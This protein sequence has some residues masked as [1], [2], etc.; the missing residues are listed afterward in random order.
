[1]SI[2]DTVEVRQVAKLGLS[3]VLTVIYVVK[4][5]A[6]APGQVVPAAKWDTAVHEL[7]A[8]SEDV[9]TADARL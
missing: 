9:D 4:L 8:E 1:M 7:P 2:N 6:V 3:W 5:L